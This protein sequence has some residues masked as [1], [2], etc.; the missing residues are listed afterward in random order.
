MVGYRLS[1][2]I[3]G[4]NFTPE[5]LKSHIPNGFYIGQIVEKG[6]VTQISPNHNKRVATYSAAYIYSQIDLAVEAEQILNVEKQFIDFLKN[7]YKFIQSI[8]GKDIILNYDVYFSD[9]YFNM[10]VFNTKQLEVL[11]N[12]NVNIALSAMQM[13]EEDI[14]NQFD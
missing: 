2:S 8:C 11:S 7:E 14:K 12:Y 4:D 10:V 6:E 13:S 9:T 1:L 3:S 5:L